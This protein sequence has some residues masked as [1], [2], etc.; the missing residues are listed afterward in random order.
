MRN[1]IKAWFVTFQLSQEGRDMGVMNKILWHTHPTI[2]AANPPEIARQEKIVT[3]LL[4]FCEIPRMVAEQVAATGW[5]GVE[6]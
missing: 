3:T 4:F 2:W 6:E 5:C 1:E